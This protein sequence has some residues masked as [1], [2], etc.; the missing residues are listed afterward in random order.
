MRFS[1]LASQSSS[2]RSAALAPKS[3]TESETDTL[4]FQCPNTGREVD[5]GI[6]AGCGARLISIRVRCPICEHLHAWRVAHRNLGAVLSGDHPSNG[7]QLNNAQTVH[8]VLEGHNV[9]I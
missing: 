4:R 9:D 1:R 3:K 6:G 8:Q 5:S 2:R 7:A